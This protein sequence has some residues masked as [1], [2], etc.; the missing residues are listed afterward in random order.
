[1]QSGLDATNRKS[2]L[3]IVGEVGRTAMRRHTC[4]SNLDIKPLSTRRRLGQLRLPRRLATRPPQRLSNGSLSYKRSL[5]PGAGCVPLPAAPRGCGLTV[6]PAGTVCPDAKFDQGAVWLS[7]TA[8]GGAN[9][10]D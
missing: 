3:N 2:T 7:L 10:E 1:M 4:N 8:P 9:C 5:P 6:H